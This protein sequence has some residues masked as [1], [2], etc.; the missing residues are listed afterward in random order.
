M[1]GLPVVMFFHGGGWVAGS[2][3]THR[4]LVGEIVEGARAVVV[5]VDY[6]RSPEARYPVALEQAYAA[7]QYVAQ[8]AREFDVDPERLVVAGDGAGG[9]L[10]AVVCLLAQERR[11][12][13]IA[14]QVLFYPFTDA[15]LDSASQ[16]AFDGGPWLTR[17][18]LQGFWDAYLP[19]GTPRGDPHVSPLRASLDELK[20]LPRALVITAENDPLRDEGEAYARKLSQAGVDV[21]SV[22]YNGTLHDFV[23]LNAL[24]QT[25]AAR[26]ALQ[27]ANRLMGAL[28]AGGLYDH[29]DT[30]E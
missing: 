26:A 14:L 1:E 9:N 30:I 24:A 8:N 5:F 25:P 11:G 20:G 27:Q 29:W 7:T 18:A 22:R 17:A 4:R 23:L 10:A 28:H 21:T 3:E 15:S 16:R 19:E 2:F 12:P 13:W 6:E